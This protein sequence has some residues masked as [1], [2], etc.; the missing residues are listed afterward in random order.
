[1]GKK[2][3]LIVALVM[4]VVMVLTIAIFKDDVLIWI[5]DKIVAYQED[6]LAWPVEGT[7]RCDE[8]D[9]ELLFSEYYNRVRLPSGEIVIFHVDYFGRFLTMPPDPQM[10]ARYHWNQKKDVVTL[11]FDEFD[12]SCEKG[13][14]YVFVNVSETT[15]TD[16]GS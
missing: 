3:W 12:Y 13:K 16:Q 15:E 10:H 11:K 6:R 2:K 8:L 14:K 7:Y 1:M 4:V 9:M 5:A